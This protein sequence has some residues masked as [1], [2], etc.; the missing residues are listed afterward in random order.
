MQ[1]LVKDLK[2]I[3][4][5]NIYENVSLQRLTTIKVGDFAKLFLM[6]QTLNSIEETIRFLHK[7]GIKYKIVG[8]GSNLIIKNSPKI[9][10]SLSKLNLIKS[11][12]KF[13]EIYSGATIA[14]FINWCIKNSLGGMESL[15][16]IPGSI[17]GAVSMNA[18]ANGIAIGDFIEEILIV[19][20]EGSF[21]QKVS[22]DTFSYRKANLPKKSLICA[23]KIRI[24]AKKGDKHCI[25]PQPPQYSRQNI[26]S[27][28]KKR[29]A[30]QP[31]NKPSA[32]C[33]FKNPP[34][35]PAWYLIAQCGL[36]G[37]FINDAQVSKKHANFIINNGRA[38]SSDIL[39]LIDIIKEKVLKETH[40]TLKEEVV[41]WQ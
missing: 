38:K 24:N 14:G 6:P 29:V 28:M 30:T 36:Q 33:I 10:L 17:G 21:W 20:K 16:G 5:L 26:Q 35:V 34:K 31:L 7:R 27:F 23:I 22:K 8:N 2:R 9:V 25:H 3:K 39:K 4:D 18:G 12:N 19:N 1:Q 15:F 40:I 37:F 11:H 13:I 32:G 41:I